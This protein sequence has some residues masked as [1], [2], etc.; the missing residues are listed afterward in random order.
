MRLL[1]IEDEKSLLDLMIHYLKNED[2]ICDAVSSYEEAIEQAGLYN[3]D[4]IIVDIMLPDGTG[5]DI[6]KN[7]KASKSE[8]GIIII[9]AKNSLED[10]ISGLELGSD[11]YLTKPFH[12]SELNARIRSVLRRK[13]YQGFEVV[14][15]GNIK[16][17]ITR[18]QV[19]VLGKAV[20][21]TPREF[22]LLLF[23]ISN[24][25]RVITK[26]S[27]ADHLWQDEFSFG[28]YDFI[29]SHIKNLR[30]KLS[31]VNCDYLKTI[32]GI[33]YKFQVN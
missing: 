11:D 31:E 22:E 27:I 7:L 15:Y 18:K 19:E 25:E 12:L 14:E 9:S 23:L 29:Y 16:L 10:K 5:L 3:Y 33:G 28:S 32:Y 6:I 1:I 26:T 20:P 24:K 8:A 4:C 2:Y 13:N 21:F 17:D 30:R